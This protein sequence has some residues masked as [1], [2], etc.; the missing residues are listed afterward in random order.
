[1]HRWANSVRKAHDRYSVEDLRMLW[2]DDKK[3]LVLEYLTSGTEEIGTTLAMIET[4]MG[5][6]MNEDAHEFVTAL[7][8]YK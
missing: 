7:L 2:K 4:F 5:M 8:K 1:M 3:D 6:T